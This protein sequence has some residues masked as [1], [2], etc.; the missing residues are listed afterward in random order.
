MAQSARFTAIASTQHTKP[1]T[2]YF[3]GISMVLQRD[4]LRQCPLGNRQGVDAA[5]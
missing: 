2:T 4:C 3:I 1:T 5:C